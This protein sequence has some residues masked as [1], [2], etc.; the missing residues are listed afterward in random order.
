[1]REI[2]MR[3]LHL[4]VISELKAKAEDAADRLGLDI[5]LAMILATQSEDGKLEAFAYQTF[6]RYLWMPGE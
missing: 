6:K 1:M 2:P 5:A 4:T 3:N